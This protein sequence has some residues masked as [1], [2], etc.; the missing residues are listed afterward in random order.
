[1][2]N[3]LD[4]QKVE[5]KVGKILEARDLEGARKPMY[6]LK[7]DIGEENPREIVA[8]IA[9]RY[10]KEELIGRRI[11]VVANLEPKRVANFPSN[12]MLLAAETESDLAL[13]TTDKDIAPGSKIH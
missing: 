4:F 6:V 13:L 10:A 8:G 11:I 3:I 2:I 7:V 9:D 12:G 1:M 5:L